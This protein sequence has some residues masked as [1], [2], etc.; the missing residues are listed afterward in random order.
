[1]GS[2][3]R[4]LGMGGASG[5]GSRS[6]HPGSTSW[7]LPGVSGFYHFVQSGI[8]GNRHTQGRMCCGNLFCFK[9]FKTEKW[10][11][12]WRQKGR[13]RV[14]HPALREERTHAGHTLFLMGI[15][16]AHGLA[17]G[18]AEICQHWFHVFPL[19]RLSYSGINTRRAHGL[20][21]TCEHGRTGNTV[22]AA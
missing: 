21:Y 1:M 7:R 20:A 2:I 17:H 14:A 5:L 4:S 15:R 19:T 11:T 12:F 3:L 18:P 16:P 10:R 22:S 9:G 6:E 8:Y 13:L